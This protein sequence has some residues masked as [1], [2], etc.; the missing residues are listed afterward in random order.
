MK[1]IPHFSISMFVLTTAFTGSGFACTTFILKNNDLQ[2]F[3]RNYDGGLDDAPL[4][5]KRGWRKK[6]NDK[7]EETGIKADWAAQHGRVA[8]SH[9]RFLSGIPGR[10][11]KC[12]RSACRACGVSIASCL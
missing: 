6:S 1:K 12:H 11:S 5:N 8:F 4:V 9:T 7:P 3:E 10:P 2:L